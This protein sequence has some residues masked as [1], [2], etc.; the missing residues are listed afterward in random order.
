MSECVDDN[1]KFSTVISDI[2][3]KIPAE[4]MT[5]EDLLDITGGRGLFMSCMILTAPFLFPVDIPGSSIP[6]GSTIF[7]ISNGIIF[8]RPVLIPKRVMGHKISKK[9]MQ[10]ILNGI[11]RVL[12][13]LEKRLLAPRFC[14]LTNGRR[15]EVIN[16][17]AVAFGGVLLVTPILAPLGDFFPAYGILFVSLGNLENDG[18]L[19][20]LGY[21]ALIGTAIYYILI[22]TV[23]ILVIVNIISYL[24]HL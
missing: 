11:S 13:P 17:V 16:G 1:E 6:F 14:S 12:K 9:D 2:S 21:S 8:K 20:L 7:L 24:G 15:M 3:S 23:T 5:L 19:V 22:F 10:S 4:G 18:Y